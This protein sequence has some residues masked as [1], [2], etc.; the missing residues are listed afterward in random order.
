MCRSRRVVRP[1]SG[2]GLRPARQ[3]N[4][5]HAVARDARER[6]ERTSHLSVR[7][8]A[9]PE[10]GC[11]RR[12]C[13]ASAAAWLPSPT[14]SARAGREPG[15]A[16]GRRRRAARRSAAAAR[17]VEPQSTTS[18][19]DVVDAAVDH[20]LPRSNEVLAKVRARTAASARPL[21]HRRP[22]AS[23]DP[24]MTTPGRGPAFHGVRA[25]VLRAFDDA[26]GG[27]I[28]SVRWG[29]PPWCRRRRNT[30][31]MLARSGDPDEVLC[32][33]CRAGSGRGAPCH[34]AVSLARPVFPVV[35]S[36]ARWPGG[37][38]PAGRERMR[39][40][41]PDVIVHGEIGAVRVQRRGRRFA[42]QPFQRDGRARCG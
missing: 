14:P 12:R 20:P 37:G 21:A 2:R 42:R 28:R 18:V 5:D 17:A 1:S 40:R 16:G 15:G 6:P 41:R 26:G 23:T 8:D 34:R 24:A 31:A 36:A 13:R 7:P 22:D 38:E 9:Q 19:L 3:P 30:D 10:L 27:T 32:T 29:A 33:R 35:L 25:R 4:F 11:G 39:T